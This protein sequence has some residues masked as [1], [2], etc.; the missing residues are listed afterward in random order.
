MKTKTKGASIENFQL[1]ILSTNDQK[2]QF[3]FE[4]TIFKDVNKNLNFF[5]FS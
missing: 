5:I 4:N 3:K 1:N 2:I